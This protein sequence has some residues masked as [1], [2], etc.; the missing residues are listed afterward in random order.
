MADE[1]DLEN[2][3]D[4]NYISVVQAI[5]LIPS[6]FDGNPKLLREFIE[7]VEAAIQVVHPNKQQL[8]L[9]F[10]ESKI[11]GD[12]KD[13]LLARTERETWIQV[14]NILEENFSVR[15]TLEYYAGVLFTSR[16]GMNETVA[17]WG[18]RL[19]GMAVDL[20]REVRSRLERLERRD[21]ARYVE[22]GLQLVGEILKGTFIAG[23]KD[24]RIK[25][26]VKAKGE[27]ESL[28]QLVETAL[29]EESE[30][31][32]QR[33]KGNQGGQWYSP[34]GSIKRDFKG[35]QGP[36]IKKEINL[37]TDTRCYRCQGLGH[38]AKNCSNVPQCGRCKRRGH[39]TRQCKQG[40][41][42]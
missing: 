25:Y 34:S 3:Q 38:V 29:Q 22:G 41:R 8:L 24:E 21:D 16:Q 17:Q 30:V 23:L 12:A 4:N 20:R 28:A 36:Q 33:F 10:I 27:E 35:S 39:E 26:I 18:S 2:D 11:T 37:A 5:K 13:R 1:N 32:S 6:T 19:D 9:K 15:R 14:K 40:N 7:G 42:Q 31:K